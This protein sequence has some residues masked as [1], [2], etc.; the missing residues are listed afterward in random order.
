MTQATAS[1][2]QVE[3]QIVAL[4]QGFLA[5]FRRRQNAQLQGVAN[6]Y[7]QAFQE[8][9]RQFH[10][11]QDLIAQLGQELVGHPIVRNGKLEL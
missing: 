4:N 10:S 1:R 11:D 5:Y 9:Q 2:S 3:H 6:S 8:A 7:A